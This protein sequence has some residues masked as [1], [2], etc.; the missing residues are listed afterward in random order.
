MFHNTAGKPAHWLVYG[1]LE[2]VPV[3]DVT[4]PQ[5]GP[6]A[7]FRFSTIEL[8]ATEQFEAWRQFSAPIIDMTLEDDLDGFA[9]EQSVWD[10][11]SFIFTRASMP[12]ARRR[13]WRHVDKDPI[14]HWCLVLP[15]DGATRMPLGF[16]SL[17][18][19]FEGA[20]ADSGVL[21]LFI[22]R[23]L[24][25]ASMLDEVPTTIPD[26]GLGRILADYL[27]SLEHRL[28]EMDMSELP[29]LIE[30]TRAMLGACL[31]P[32]ATRVHE[33]REPIAATMLERARRLIRVD[34]GAPD[35]GP[36]KLCRTLGVSR[37][38]LYRLFV[39]LGGVMRYIQRQRLLAAHAALSR[40]DGSAPILQV[41]ESVGFMD[42]SGFS[43]AFRQEFGYTPR[44][45]REAASI[46][47]P[48]APARGRPAINGIPDLGAALR[49][50]GA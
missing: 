37:S 3:V 36:D 38:R 29:G 44:E 46:G 16:R 32:T 47:V 48:R 30:A 5:A 34:L 1:C 27:L 45:A 6:L 24:F 33:A 14:D 10:L 41:A 23:D 19:P 7:P 15:L 43:R 17:A 4:S 26:T 22:P 18:R 11:G 31:S 2:N 8:A 40:A 9:A 25:G 21:S 39:P 35:L 42:A 20:A 13:A 49:G 28:P 12:G 50:L